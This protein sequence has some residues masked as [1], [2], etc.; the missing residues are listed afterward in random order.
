[1]NTADPLD[2]L[3]SALAKLPAIGRRSAERIALKL[4]QNNKGLSEELVASLQ[5]A[6]KSVCCCS[7]CGSITTKEQ[8][9]CR[10]CTDP[11]RDD[12]VLCVV[13]DP[14]D[15]MLIERSGGFRGR[16]H[17][18]LGK[19]SPMKGEGVDDIRATELAKRVKDEGVKEIILALNSDVESDATA[20]FLH[21]ML[22]SKDVKVTRIAFG[23]PAGSGIAYSDPVTLSRAIEGR[24]EMP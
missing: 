11:R 20:G 21:D 6:H 19:I 14:G 7:K 8:N 3:I 22:T 1:V 2:R 24:T 4:V 17:A 9:P 13:E 10:L 16:Y 23:L 12:S 15:I 5:A 18:L